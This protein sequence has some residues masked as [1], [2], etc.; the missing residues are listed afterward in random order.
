MTIMTEQGIP[1]WQSERA[2]HQIEG[3]QEVPPHL[4]WRAADFRFR[5]TGV[6]DLRSGAEQ[7]SIALSPALRTDQPHNTDESEDGC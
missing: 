4:R 1:N 5:L 7:A 2:T 3:S 6:M